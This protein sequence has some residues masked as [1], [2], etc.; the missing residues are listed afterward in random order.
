MLSLAEYLIPD[1]E[2]SEC[3][4]CDQSFTW[5]IRKHHCRVCGGVVCNNCSKGRISRKANDPAVRTCDPCYDFYESQQ[6]QLSSI[7]A[8]EAAILMNTVPEAPKPSSRIAA[9]RKKAI[10][11][12]RLDLRMKTKEKTA[13]SLMKTPSSGIASSASSIVISE[14]ETETT[15]SNE[16]GSSSSSSSSEDQSSSSLSSTPYSLTDENDYACSNIRGNAVQKNQI[17]QK[18]RNTVIKNSGLCV[19]VDHIIRGSALEKLHLEQDARDDEEDK[20]LL[21]K[22]RIR[23]KKRSPM[24]IERIEEKDNKNKNAILSNKD[25]NKIENGLKDL[26]VVTT[27]QLENDEEVKWEKEGEVEKDF[28]PR[29]GKDKRNSRNSLSSRIVS[30][31]LN[32]N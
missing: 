4:V 7:R 17:L 30:S 31:A 24:A 10:T 16:T 23:L 5:I 14:A 11:S 9:F 29:E 32:A 22:E 12:L 15:I 3:Q 8:K 2:V 26:S 19:N 6:E 20:I 27:G 1:E 25:E 13:S 28:P 18:K 21:E